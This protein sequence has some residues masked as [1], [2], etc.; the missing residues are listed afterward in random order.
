[1]EDSQKRFLGIKLNKKEVTKILKNKKLSSTLNK[2]L[3]KAG[4]EDSCEKAIGVTLYKIAC[5]KLQPFEVCEERRLIVVDYYMQGKLENNL[6]LTAALTYLKKIGKG[7]FVEEE[8]IK[9][10]GIGVVIKEETIKETTKNYVEENKE[11]DTFNMRNAILELKRAL[12]WVEPR[13]IKQNLDKYMKENNVQFS[14][15]KGK[16]SKLENKVKKEKFSLPHENPLNDPKILKKHLKETGGKVMT[17]FPPEPNGFLHIGHGKAMTFNF[18]YAQKQN[19]H[20][21]LRFDDTNPDKEK[22]EY[23]DSII[24]NVSW[25]GFKIYK[26]TYTSDYYQNL[27][28]YAIELIKR[29]LAYV[30]HQTSEEISLGRKNATN[31]PWRDRPIEE[32]LKEFDLMTKGFYNEGEASLRLKMDM[33]N[34][35]MCMRDLIAY[36]IKFKSHPR[37]GNKWC[38]YPSYDYSHCVIDSLEN[39][40]HSLCTLEFQIRQKSYYWVLDALK[41]YKPIVWEYGRLNLTHTIMSKRKL[42]YLV[43]EKI[44]QGWNDPVMPTISGLRRRGFTATAIKEFCKQIGVTRKDEGLISVLLLEQV[45]RTELNRDCDRKFAVIDPLKVII[46]NFGENETQVFE[47]PNHP[48]L[49]HGKRPLVMSNVIYIERSDFRLED[50]KDYYGLAPNKEVTLKY[51][52]NITCKDFVK[53]NEGNVLEIHCVADFE[54]KRVPKGKIHWISSTPKVPLLK[55][56]VRLYDRLIKIEDPST[57]NDW[58]TVLNKNYLTVKNNCLIESSLQTIKTLDRFQFERLGYFVVDE[59]STGDHLVFNKTVPLKQSKSKKS[60]N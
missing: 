27:Y 44:V 37:T 36:R 38:I 5:F 60:I 59:D 24:E 50:S 56:E 9:T 3:D 8:F 16:K 15:A 57:V 40:T 18:G 58:H 32:S 11:L 1:M 25:F 34:D 55:A 41:L 12:L 51:A 45:L 23:I 47:A 21:Y 29:D 48:R 46:S 33:Q 30:C 7:E 35:N 54:K 6:K 26:I 49:D 19:G 53:D 20:C 14:K 28:D 42:Q 22:Q 17:R 13:I 10:S 4:V 52:F 2:V 43:K 31:S 39:I